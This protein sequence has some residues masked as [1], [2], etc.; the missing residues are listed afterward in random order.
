[1]FRQPSIE[2]AERQAWHRPQGTFMYRF[3]WE[4]PFGGGKLGAIHGLEMAFVFD[5]LERWG[6][7]IG[8]VESAQ[9]V[10]DAMADAWVSFA[11]DGKPSSSGLPE[12]PT[13]DATLRKTMIL[14]NDPRIESDPE[15]VLRKIWQDALMERTVPSVTAAR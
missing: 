4:T 9:P 3:D 13:Y 5:N 7:L 12:W 8:D 1:M 10:A 15:G 6:E 14:G 11:A 2:L